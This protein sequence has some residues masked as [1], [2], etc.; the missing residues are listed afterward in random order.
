MKPNLGN[1][2]VKTKKSVL[3][4]FKYKWS[5]EPLFSIFIALIIMVI[6]QTLVLGFDYDSFGEWFQSWTN[7]WI[8]ILRNNAGIGIV[9]LGMT[10][11]IMTGG[12]DLAVG[13]T[14]VITGAFAMYLLDTGTKGILGMMGMTGVPA[15]ALTI[16]LVLLL[17]YLLGSLIGL[18]ITKGKVPPFIAT[19][20]AMMIFRSVTQHFTQGYN[21]TVP[22]EFLQ[23]S[24]FKI[25]N[26]MIM[27]IIYWAVIAYILYYVS[28]RTTFGR[29][30][31]AV[32]SN[33][34][35]AKLSGVNVEKVKLR[36][37]ALMGL[38]VSIAAIIQVS[39]IGSMDYSNAGRGMEMDAIAAAVVGGTS[40]A[41]GRGFIL[42]TVYG[43]LI[44]AVMN[45]LLNLFGVPPFL[46]EAFKGVIVVGAVL[47][48]KKEKTS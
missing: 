44:I 17:G 38:L 23:I 28:K 43:M 3:E 30:I 22:M 37:Y 20:G 46:R 16:I 19:L 10:F 2:Q 13:S 31:I 35:A 29:Q 27:P 32:G 5:N 26:Y 1:A 21:T 39:R 33:E 7:N 6:L 36:V 11:V 9:A 8:N 34:R 18:S 25:G 24:S 15:I 4:W 41:G 48:Q 47:L 14:L 45:N 40:M 12:I 42:G